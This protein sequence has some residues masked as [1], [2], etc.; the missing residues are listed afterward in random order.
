M[1]DATSSI[2]EPMAAAPLQYRADG[3]VDWGNMWDDF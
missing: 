1:S 2:A 3:S